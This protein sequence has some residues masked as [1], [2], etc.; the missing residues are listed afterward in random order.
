M[1]ASVP[2]RLDHRESSDTYCAEIIRSGRWRI[3]EGS[4][5]IQWVL[6]YQ[7]RCGGPD[8]AR[9]EGKHFCRT[10]DALVRLWHQFTGQDGALVEALL[11]ERFAKGGYNGSA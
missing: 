10:R 6:Q 9:W 3:I 4:C 7:A 8:T 2:I 1:N 5:G 11:P